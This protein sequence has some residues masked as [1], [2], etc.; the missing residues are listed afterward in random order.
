MKKIL[1]EYKQLKNFQAITQF[2][3]FSN[4]KPGQQK[5]AELQALHLK[6]IR[7]Q[8]RIKPLTNHY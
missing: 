8:T 2:L 5:D 3:T 7:N 4:L 6:L 1:A